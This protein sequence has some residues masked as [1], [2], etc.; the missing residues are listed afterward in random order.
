MDAVVFD[1]GG[2]L[3]TS[4]VEAVT[5]WMTAEG[6]DPAS[7]GAVMGDW[8]LDVGA[9]STPI[10]LLETGELSAILVAIV[11]PGSERTNG[12]DK[13]AEY[14]EAGIPYYW[15]VDITGPVSFIECRLDKDSRYVDSGQ[16]TGEFKTTEPFPLSLDLNALL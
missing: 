11:S 1:Y 8:L 6:I 7:Y 5:S 15:M 2:V 3:T 10:H 4:V 13:R 14:G 12:V 9:Q 16:I